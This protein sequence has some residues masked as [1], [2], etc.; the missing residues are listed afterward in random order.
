M[1][2]GVLVPRTPRDD[3]ES[4]LFSIWTVAGMR[5]DPSGKPDA[6]ILAEFRNRTNAKSRFVV[7]LRPIMEN[8]FKKRINKQSDK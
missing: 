1:E 5:L 3:F 8:Y 7:G 6:M 4:L 2:T